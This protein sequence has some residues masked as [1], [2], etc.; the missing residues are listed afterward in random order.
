[1]FCTVSPYENKD[2][3]IVG[4][5]NDVKNV[6]RT[7]LNKPGNKIQVKKGVICTHENKCYKTRLYLRVHG[8]TSF[9]LHFQSVFL[10]T[11]NNNDD[12]KSPHV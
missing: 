8:E 12:Y 3:V 4:I 6:K 2:T 1:M 5:Q 9:S 7:T 10:A 11:G